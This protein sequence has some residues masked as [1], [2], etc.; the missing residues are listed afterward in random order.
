MVN[1]T[2]LVPL[3]HYI[4]VKI[5]PVLEAVLE[6]NKDTLEWEVQCWFNYYL[7]IWGLMFTSVIW[8]AVKDSFMDAH[9][10][11]FHRNANNC[12][13]ITCIMHYVYCV[14]CCIC[15]YNAVHCTDH[16]CTHR[17][18]HGT[19]L[20]KYCIYCVSSP[21]LHRELVTH[22]VKESQTK[23]CDIFLLPAWLLFWCSTKFLR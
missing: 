20:L 1:C 12:N 18:R 14:Q 9:C 11:G 21:S 13:L 16:K 19:F 10:I 2:Q 15:E 8:Y 6:S 17:G 5:M 23:I 7:P 4:V 22:K 3:Q